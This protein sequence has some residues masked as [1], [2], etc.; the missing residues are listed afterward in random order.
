[1]GTKGAWSPERRAKQAIIIAQTRPWEK[2]TGPRTERGK[3]NSARNAYTG[4]AEAA[5]LYKS[6]RMQVRAEALSRADQ[7]SMRLDQILAY[8]SDVPLDDES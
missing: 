2:A 1:M 7:M 5:A 6:I 4:A 8:K 3:A